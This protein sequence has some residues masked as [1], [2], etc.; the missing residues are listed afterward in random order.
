[1]MIMAYATTKIPKTLAE[2]VDKLVD[3]KVK[4]YR[5]R[6]EFVTEAVREKLKA[7]DEELHEPR[8]K[9]INV[10]T[11]HATLWDNLKRKLVDVYFREKEAW[12]EN[13]NA[14]NC[15]HV[16]YALSL[17]EVR[18]SYRKKGLRIPELE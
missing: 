15:D 12:C 14:V 9:H 1:M 13:D 8:F 18:E 5:S 6:M 16:K 7:F 17:A 11:D 4:G 10:Y 2:D 3:A